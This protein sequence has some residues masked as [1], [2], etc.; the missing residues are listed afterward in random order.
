MAVKLCTAKEILLMAFSI[1]TGV[2]LFLI[3]RYRHQGYLRLL[4]WLV[5]LFIMLL[6]GVICLIIVR[7]A[8]KPED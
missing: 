6:G 7:Y 4:E 3:I 2:G 5:A 1:L 8:N